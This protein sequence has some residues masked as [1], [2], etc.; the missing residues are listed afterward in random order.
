[1][2]LVFFMRC[3]SAWEFHGLFKC[4]IWGRLLSHF[5][6][7]K[8]N[9]PE[10]PGSRAGIKEKHFGLRITRHP[11]L[12]GEIAYRWHKCCD[13]DGQSDIASVIL[14]PLRPTH[15]PYHHPL[16]HLLC[17]SSCSLI[18]PLP[19]SLSLNLFFFFLKNHISHN[20]L[21]PY[22]FWVTQVFSEFFRL[23]FQLGFFLIHYVLVCGHQHVDKQTSLLWSFHGIKRLQCCSVWR[24][25]DRTCPSTAGEQPQTCEH[26]SV[27]FCSN[28][29]R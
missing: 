15:S 21:I 12:M 20:S 9:I 25:A 17:L 28:Q 13:I 27:N 24:T 1:M 26:L 4:W 7:D 22:H 18:P 2:L 6:N 5:I 3:P 29:Y 11:I 14:P 10:R 8:E 23:S 16:L 19:L